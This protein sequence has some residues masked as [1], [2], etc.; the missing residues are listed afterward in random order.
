MWTLTDITSLI[1]VVII[2]VFHWWRERELA[3]SVNS[4]SV[5]ENGSYR[6]FRT[7][8]NDVWPLSNMSADDKQEPSH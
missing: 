5:I 6:Q 4:S 2:F 3:L 1:L 7:D 8:M